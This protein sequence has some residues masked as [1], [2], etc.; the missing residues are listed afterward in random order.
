MDILAKPDF[1]QKLITA[2]FDVTA[3]DA[4]GHAERIA[5]EIPKFKQIIEDAKIQK[6]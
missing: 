4:K 3:K 6:L 5:R 2:G 1:R